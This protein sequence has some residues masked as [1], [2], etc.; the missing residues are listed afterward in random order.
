ME[1]VAL[2]VNTVHYYQTV[3]CVSSAIRRINAQSTVPFQWLPFQYC[4]RIFKLFKHKYL[5]L[6]EIMT[7][8][9]NEGIGYQAYRKN[10]EI[11][12]RIKFC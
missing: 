3:S 12:K 9:S 5:T 11:N 7:P 1:V 4:V 2:V 6:E 8:L 10:V